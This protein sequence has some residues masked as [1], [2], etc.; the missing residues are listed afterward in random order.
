LCVNPDH[1]FI[2][3]AKDN[4]VDRDKKKRRVA[5]KGESHGRSKLKSEQV[6]E[7][8]SL[9]SA[10]NSTWELGKRYGVHP[11]TIR[12]IVDRKIWFHL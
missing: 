3:T 1:I 8:R 4:A 5:P 12:E 10:G 9:F 7:I 11:K 6:L 2:G